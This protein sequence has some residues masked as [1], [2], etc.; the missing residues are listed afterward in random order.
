MKRTLITT[1]LLLS[2]LSSAIWAQGPPLLVIELDEEKVNLSEDER[3][4]DTAT[5]Y[6]PGDTIRYTL[7]ASNE[8]G[9]LMTQPEVLDPIP[10][11]VTYISGSAT[12]ENSNIIFSI[13]S[14]VSFHNWP[15]SYTVRN[16]NGQEIVHQASADMITHVKWQIQGNLAVGETRLLQFLVE[17]N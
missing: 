1:I 12:G 14:G 9:S 6:F 15:V 2:M 7:T 8:G 16:T 17:V 10:A 13:D 5:M 3:S 4:G 11:G